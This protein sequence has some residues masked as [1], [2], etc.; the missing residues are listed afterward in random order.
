MRYRSRRDFMRFA[1]EGNQA[2]KFVHKWAAIE[3]THV[4][5][6]KPILNLFAVRTLVGLLLFSLGAI[7]MRALS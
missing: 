6:V 5:P 7:L 1:I 3:K 2:E 4:F